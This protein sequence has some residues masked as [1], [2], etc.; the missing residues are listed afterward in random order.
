MEDVGLGGDLTH[1]PELPEKFGQV[2]R[3]L[4]GHRL[5][6]Q[7]HAVHHRPPP[8]AVA[9]SSMGGAG[10]RVAMARMSGSS[11][12]ENRTRTGSCAP[13]RWT[14]AVPGIEA[15]IRWQ[16]APRSRAPSPRTMSTWLSSA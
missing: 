7:A 1:G 13:S 8:A 4:P 2:V 6:L 10:Q 12:K 11:L 3:R 9:T 14:N 15:G 5:R 16:A